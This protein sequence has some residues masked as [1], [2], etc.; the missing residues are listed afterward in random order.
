MLQEWGHRGCL[1]NSRARVGEGAPPVDH[2]CCLLHGY[3]QIS[4]AQ[5]GC[6]GL[7]E[8]YVHPGKGLILLVELLLQMKVFGSFCLKISADLQ[9]L[10]SGDSLLE[11]LPW[12][13][14]QLFE[15]FHVLLQLL[16]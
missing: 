10:G 7:K 6:D 11:L 4:F 2:C 5:E 15:L 16:D 3:P 12:S 8:L 9:L 13:S 14:Q 1:V